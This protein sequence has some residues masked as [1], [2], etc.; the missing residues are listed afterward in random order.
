MNLYSLVLGLVLGI[1]RVD[2]VYAGMR[3]IEFYSA[4]PA[5]SL[6]LAESA[7]IYYKTDWNNAFF[8]YVLDGNNWT[9]V[10]GVVMQ[11]SEYPGYK[12]IEV[13]TDGV[14][15]IEGIFNNGNGVW[16][17]NYGQNYIITTDVS[18]VEDGMIIPSEPYLDTFTIYYKT[19]WIM[20]IYTMPSMEAVGLSLPRRSWMIVNILVIRKL[21]ILE[22]V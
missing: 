15:F 16:D 8:H 17:N 10:P 14:Q 9:N 20:H 12:L 3:D 11:D 7:K 4:N 1:V 18:T 6:K 13:A 22:V 2:L 19:D 21:I 5:V